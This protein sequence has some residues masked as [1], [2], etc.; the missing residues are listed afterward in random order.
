M[1]LNSELQ[2]HLA[3]ISQDTY[4]IVPDVLF[5]ETWCLPSSL[6][7]Y[8]NSFITAKMSYKNPTCLKIL[9]FNWKLEVVVPVINLDL[10]YSLS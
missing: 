1:V 6:V 5:D 3:Q 10:V 2:G 8:F 4:F 7:Q 9:S